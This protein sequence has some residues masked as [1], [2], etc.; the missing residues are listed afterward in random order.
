MCSVSAASSPPPPSFCAFSVRLRRN[1]LYSRAPT[2]VQALLRTREWNSC[3][4]SSQ[5]R[6][7]GVRVLLRYWL[8]TKLKI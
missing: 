4:F 5:L 1:T 7:S 8:G 2:T 3:K 6:V